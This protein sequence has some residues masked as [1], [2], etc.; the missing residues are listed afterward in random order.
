MDATAERKA[1]NYHETPKS[2]V[3]EHFSLEFRLARG[4]TLFVKGEGNSKRV[5]IPKSSRI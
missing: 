1:Q 2:V 4:S 5:G 3:P